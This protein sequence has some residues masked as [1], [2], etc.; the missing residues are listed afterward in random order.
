LL[1]RRSTVIAWYVS[2]LSLKQEYDLAP[3]VFSFALERIC[4]WEEEEI[5]EKLKL[6][7]THQLMLCIDINLLG[8]T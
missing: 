2:Y 8:I 5:W 4:Y 6:N 3:L 7:M 1:L